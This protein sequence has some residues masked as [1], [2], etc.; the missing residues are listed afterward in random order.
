MLKKLFLFCSIVILSGSIFAQDQIVKTNGEEILGK[1]VRINS[2]DVVYKK[3]ENLD[4]PEYFELKSNILFIKYEN[5]QRDIFTTISTTTN[6]SG[7]SQVTEVITSTP[8][9]V[10]VPIKRK[11]SVFGEIGGNNLI[12]S[13]NYERKFFSKKNYNFAT[14]K[15]GFVPFGTLCI[16]NATATYNAGD[17]IN[18]FEAGGGYGTYTNQL[19][20]PSRNVSVDSYGYF[21]PIAGYRRQAPNGFLIRV[22]ITTIA[23][24]TKE[25]TYD[26][27]VS[28]T[29]QYIR[30]Y[31][32]FGAS[33]GYSF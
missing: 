18:Y 12:M 32:F 27:G 25:T 24:K 11:N 1:V 13:L 8:A 29:E 26:G 21:T 22:F 16:L 31:P 2:L 10:Y 14:L 6:T 30:Y 33:F 7:N 23:I 9:P 19:F 3:K 28:V 17:G 4:G 5:G 20:N 15:G